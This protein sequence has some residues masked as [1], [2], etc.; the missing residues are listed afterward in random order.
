M[1]EL[2][3]NEHEDHLPPL[4]HPND[5]QHAQAEV[6]EDLD[7]GRAENSERHRHH[8]CD[9]QSQ[10]DEH[11]C[12]EEQRVLVQGNGH[13]LHQGLFVLD[14]GPDLVHEHEGNQGAEHSAHHGDGHELRHEQVGRGGSR[15]NR[16]AQNIVP[17]R[18]QDSSLHF[19]IIQS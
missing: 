18:I 14:C 9:L 15:P 19:I 1:R 5:H 11:D 4:A 8:V 16:D 6:H 2:L 17:V 12:G 3:A 10:V 7:F 13:S